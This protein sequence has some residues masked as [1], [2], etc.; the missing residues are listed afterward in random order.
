MPDVPQGRA[1]DQARLAAGLTV[2]PKCRDEPA[3]DASASRSLTMARNST[4]G[5]CSRAFPPSRE[6]SKKSSAGSKASPCMS[7]DRD[8]RMPESMRAPR[9]PRSR[10]T[11]PIPA[12]NLRRAI[13]RLLPPAIRVLDAI[14][15]DAD[16]HPRFDAIAK[17][18][19]YTHPSRADLFAVR[20]A[21][22]APLS[23]SA[24]RGRDDCGRA[25]SSKASTISPHS[26][27]RTIATTKENRR[28]ARSSV[29]RLARVGGSPDLHGSRQRISQAH[30][31][32]YRGNTHRN[33]PRKSGSDAHHGL[34]SGAS[35]HKAGPT[36]PAKGL[37]PASRSRYA[38]QHV[39]LSP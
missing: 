10:S 11:I 31:A 35:T 25:G 6:F 26:P 15:T 22:R 37:S 21:L 20:M 5:R 12:D 30:G 7:R 19:Q 39:N 36:A 1:R 28:C 38:A 34:F 24:G 23:L 14:E 33:R 29:R 8:A 17:T 9:S 13:N 2:S 4:A 32:E 3:S 18:Y 16:F 27:L